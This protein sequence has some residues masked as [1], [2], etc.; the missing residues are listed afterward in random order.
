MEA[1]RFDLLT[2]KKLGYNTLRK[3]VSLTIYWHRGGP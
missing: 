3:H 1:M 2:L